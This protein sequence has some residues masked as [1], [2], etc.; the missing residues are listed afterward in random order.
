[1][2]N[3]QQ[4]PGAAITTDAAVICQPGYSKSVRHTSGRLKHDIYVE[5]GINRDD[6]NYEIDHLI[7]LGVGGADTR[8]NLWPESRDTQPWNATVKD[9]L[10]NYLHVEICARRIPVSQAQKEIAVDW[11]A[12]YR[13][14]IGNPR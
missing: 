11:V 12:A 7:P 4:T 5:Y 14:Y 1:L 13:K 9:R 8:E 3:A 10:E 6:G 2:P